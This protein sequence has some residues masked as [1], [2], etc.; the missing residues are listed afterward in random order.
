MAS[1]A[2]VQY[3]QITLEMQN[4][5]AWGEEEWGVLLGRREARGVWERKQEQSI[6]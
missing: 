6:T 5:W 2:T 3:C 1:E 4:E